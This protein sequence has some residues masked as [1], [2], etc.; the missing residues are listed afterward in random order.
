MDYQF[1]FNA[2]MSVIAMVSTGG[3]IYGAIR[4]DLRHMHGAIAD[5]RKMAERAHS[6]LDTHIE[7]RS[8]IKDADECG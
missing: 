8:R 5:V 3:A 2:A 7:G 4:S 1:M 6:R